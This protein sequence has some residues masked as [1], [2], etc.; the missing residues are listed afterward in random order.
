MPSLSI[1]SKSSIQIKKKSFLSFN[2]SKAY[3][4]FYSVPFDMSRFK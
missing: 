1:A 4:L 2:P 3:M